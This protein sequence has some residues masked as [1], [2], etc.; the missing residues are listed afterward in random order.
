MVKKLT[1]VAV[2]LAVSTSGAALAQN[3]GPMPGG[4]P[5]GMHQSPGP[6]GP[7]G[8][9]MPG[10]PGMGGGIGVMMA[11]SCFVADD[12]DGSK[13]SAFKKGFYAFLR[14]QYGKMRGIDDAF[15][16]A[17]RSAQ[18]TFFNAMI[19]LAEQSEGGEDEED[20]ENQED[21]MEEARDEMES[22][23]EEANNKMRKARR[24][25]EK[26]QKSS[27]KALKTK[28]G[29]SNSPRRT[30]NFEQ[31]G[32]QGEGQG[33]QPMEPRNGEGGQF[34]PQGGGNGSEGGSDS[35]PRPGDG[36]QGAPSTST[37]TER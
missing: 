30:Q 35:G 10:G 21:A 13:A 23:I 9:G 15:T 6:M 22:A 28:H 5:E 31:R 29:C 24:A 7:Q 36:G 8:G 34:R 14:G 20:F 25:A 16:A 11:P 3:F 27:L 17:T 26:E 37:G 2:A 4:P 32:P 12:E 19:D 33:F 1:I 18:D